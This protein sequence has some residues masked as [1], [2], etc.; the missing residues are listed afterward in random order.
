MGLDQYLEA[1]F[2][3][4]DTWEDTA[5]QAKQVTDICGVPDELVPYRQVTIRVTLV[6]WRNA[7]WLHDY[8]IK[9]AQACSDAM[10]CYV[11]DRVLLNFIR[12]S[13]LVLNNSA[14]LDDLFPEPT[15][16]HEINKQ[17]RRIDET[18]RILKE[19]RDDFTKI[20]ARMPQADFYYRSDC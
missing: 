20:L 1:D 10:T 12:D 6:H 2:Y 13:D 11:D 3:F 16:L 19:T 15:W 4:S 5:T 17:P 8:I 18:R 14:S 9:D 7:H